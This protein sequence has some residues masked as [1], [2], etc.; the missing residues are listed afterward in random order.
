M[1]KLLLKN[2]DVHR[3]KILYKSSR[4]LFI[5]ITRK[6]GSVSGVHA[7]FSMESV[8]LA[9]PSVRDGTLVKAAETHSSGGGFQ[10]KAGSGH[11]LF[12]SHFVSQHCAR[13]LPA[14]AAPH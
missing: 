2:R 4:C 1:I 10:L 14:N 13:N 12:P 6:G 5:L 7:C 9:Q 3:K 11:A 8:T